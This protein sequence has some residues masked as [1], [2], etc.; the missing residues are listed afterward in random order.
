MRGLFSIDGPFFTFMSRVADFII[1]NLLFIVCSLPI[2]TIGASCTAMSYVTMKM[3]DGDE[4]YI[5][6]SFFKSFK[7]NFKQATGMWMIYLLIAAVLGVDLYV[8]RHSTG[9]GWKA[10]SVFITAGWVLWFM[11]VSWAFPLMARFVNT[12]KGTMH[13][14]L[15]LA[16]GNAPKTIAFTLI[17]AGCGFITIYNTT[18]FI[19]GLLVWILV[20]FS[21][22]SYLN[23]SF[24]Y[25]QI[26]ALM[27]EET[28]E[29]TDDMDFR[30]DEG[31]EG[32]AAGSPEELEQMAGVTP[33]PGRDLPKPEDGM[34]K[35]EDGSAEV[36][37]S[38]GSPGSAGEEPSSENGSEAG[39]EGPRQS[40]E[41]ENGRPKENPPETG[42]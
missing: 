10:M 39:E 42:R 1:L 15:Y 33:I 14:A 18:T 8:V 17:C 24:Q 26:H 4:G 28:D 19:W 20:G 11:I 25:K 21:A 12:V 31:E 36:T 2:F 34:K 35:P 29:I 32:T 41:P 30:V 7:E 38:G 40:G 16:I 22:L 13:N 9:S 27:P 5:A 37:G 3:K 6:K 23:S